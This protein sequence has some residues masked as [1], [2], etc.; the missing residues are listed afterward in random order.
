MQ[1]HDL[2]H[3]NMENRE[4]KNVENTDRIDWLDLDMEEFSDQQLFE[5]MRS[6]PLG[7][8][9]RLI[10]TLPEVRREKVQRARQE[11]RRNG[12]EMED[13]LDL[14]LDRVLEELILED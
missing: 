9:L 1:T 4:Q 12:P 7:R 2:F 13:R 10:G 14:A 8:L 5:H 6:N 3:S 11:I